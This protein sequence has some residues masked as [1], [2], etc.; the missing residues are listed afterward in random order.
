MQDPYGLAHDFLLYKASPQRRA[1]DWRS[2]LVSI[3]K[4]VTTVPKFCPSV[5]II[6]TATDAPAGV[7]RCTLTYSAPHSNSYCAYEAIRTYE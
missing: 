2:V 6:V 7:D 1:R 3:G 5:N 4:M